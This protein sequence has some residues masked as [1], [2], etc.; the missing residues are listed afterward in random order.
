MRPHT[1]SDLPTL[2]PPGGQ[3]PLVELAGVSVDIDR[4]P[5]LRGV[6]LVLRHG[7]VVGVT[8]P[9]GSGKSTLLETLA[10]LRRPSAGGGTLLGADIGLPVPAEVRRRICLVGHQPALYPQ[11]SLAENLRFVAAL[12]GRPQEAADEALA[13]VGLRRSADRR[14]DRCSMGM[15]RR[16]DL[17]RVFLVEPSLLLLDE[18]H[19]GLDERAAELVDHLIGMVSEDGGATVVVAHDRQRLTRV[20]NHIVSLSGGRLSPSGHRL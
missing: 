1:E 10:T 6:N 15:S 12:L 17:A 7:S 18:A 11:L 13:A 20:A 2:S 9:N 16:A 5:I 8:G 3:R 14:V 19:A 4:S